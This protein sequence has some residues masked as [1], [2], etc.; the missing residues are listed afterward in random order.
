[1]L[2]QVRVERVERPTGRRFAFVFQELVRV[3]QEKIDVE[4]ERDSKSNAALC[5]RTRRAADELARISS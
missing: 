4:N 3:E 5:R 1:M 2:R